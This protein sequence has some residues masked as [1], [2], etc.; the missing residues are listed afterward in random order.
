MY[1]KYLLKKTLKKQKTE[2]VPEERYQYR[3]EINLYWV[4]N[5]RDDT[6][7]ASQLTTKHLL[8]NVNYTILNPASWASVWDDENNA[9]IFFNTNDL[10]AFGP[11]V[12]SEIQNMKNLELS[13]NCITFVSNLKY[14]NTTTYFVATNTRQQLNDKSEIVSKAIL[15]AILFNWDQK[16]NGIYI[17]YITRF[18]QG[19]AFQ[20]QVEKK[21]SSQYEKFKVD[22]LFS[23]VMDQIKKIENVK[24][25]SLQIASDGSRQLIEKH[26]LKKYFKSWHKNPIIQRAN[27]TFPLKYLQFQL[28]SQCV[29]NIATVK[30]ENQDKYSFCDEECARFKWKSLCLF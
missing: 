24:T 1:D 23:F 20:F 7:S 4:L 14:K 29:N 8:R 15:T 17:E 10:T 6:N 13:F 16:E 19:I 5:P 25:V 12:R 21:T 11:V 3:N 9:S 2:S 27:Q 28:C 30:W 18:Y 26:L 22:E